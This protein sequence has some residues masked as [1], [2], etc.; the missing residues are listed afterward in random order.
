M[1][2]ELVEVKCADGEN[3]ASPVCYQN[4]APYISKWRSLL[5]WSSKCWRSEVWSEAVSHRGHGLSPLSWWDITLLK[6]YKPLTLFS[7][8]P[9]QHPRS[10]S[11]LVATSAMGGAFVKHLAT[12]CFL[13][14]S[15][16]IFFTYLKDKFPPQGCHWWNGSQNGSSSRLHLVTKKGEYL[17]YLTMESSKKE[18]HVNLEQQ[19]YWKGTKE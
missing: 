7:P 11:S 10:C 14:H 19:D 17:Q 6:C 4:I 16:I 15:R 2:V 13:S 5:W 1:I 3:L 12:S 18:S 9:K 8:R